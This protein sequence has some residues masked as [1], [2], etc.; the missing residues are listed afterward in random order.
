[1]LLPKT[2]LE[3]HGTHVLLA[4]A[5]VTKPAPPAVLAISL[6]QTLDD[7]AHWSRQLTAVHLKRTLVAKLIVSVASDNLF[8]TD[9]GSCPVSQFMLCPCAVWVFHVA[10]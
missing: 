10:T 4:A 9:T 6:R 1:M 7:N 8:Y 2:R 5:T 3:G